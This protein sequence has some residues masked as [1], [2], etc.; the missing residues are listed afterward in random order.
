[1]ITDMKVLTNSHSVASA[2]SDGTVHV[3]CVDKVN[4]VGGN[5]QASGLKELRA[6]NLWQLTT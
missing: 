3:F 4:A 2:S 1:M 6:N 5:V